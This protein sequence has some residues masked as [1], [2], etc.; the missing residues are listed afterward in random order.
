MEAAF[1]LQKIENYSGIVILATNF[2]Q[3][4]DEAFKRRIDFP[5]EFPFPGK[6]QR[7][8][9]WKN[10]FPPE[11]RLGKLDYNY[12]SDNFELS[13]NNIKN[14]AVHSAF[15]AAASQDLNDLQIDPQIEMKHII[16]AIK[17]EFA[18]SG[19]AFTKSEA[20]EYSD[21]LPDNSEK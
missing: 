18:K 21:Y 16:P 7:R 19:K 13:G 15:L 9:L 17:N 20:G 11:T 2:I 12:L 8:E 1:L 10:V 5:V 4:F 14:I 6:E 3:N